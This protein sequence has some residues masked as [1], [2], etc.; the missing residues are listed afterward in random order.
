VRAF[1]ARWV[2]R[3]RRPGREVAPR[4]ASPH[5]AAV[6]E[7]SSSAYGAQGK[8]HSAC[9]DGR[10]DAPHARL[11]VNEY[12]VDRI[13]HVLNQSRTG[14][15]GYWNFAAALAADRGLGERPALTRLLSNIQRG[16]EIRGDPE[17]HAVGRMGN[18]PGRRVQADRRVEPPFVAPA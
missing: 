6:P 10:T 7:R 9:P 4:G 3:A 12:H 8:T 2:N 1:S 14:G 18:V 17:Q 15:R 16:P 11:P 13:A 5:R